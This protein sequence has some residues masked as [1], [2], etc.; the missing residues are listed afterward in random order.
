[1]RSLLITFIIT[2]SLLAEDKTLNDYIL[3]SKSLSKT[4]LQIN[5]QKIIKD[6]EHNATKKAFIEKVFLDSNITY[7]SDYLFDD[8][9]AEKQGALHLL[10][11]LLQSHV[12]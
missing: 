4:E 6:A 2:L 5:L 3:E 8:M 7:Q 9:S 1:M 12:N 11:L 10:L